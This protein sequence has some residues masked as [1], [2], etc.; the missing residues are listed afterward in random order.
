MEPLC[1]TSPDSPNTSAEPA[2]TIKQCGHVFGRDCLAEWMSEHNT[3]PVCR[4]EFF[5]AREERQLFALGVYRNFE[6]RVDG[7]Q[8]GVSVDVSVSV[9]NGGGNGT[10]ERRT[11]GD[12]GN[13]R[14]RYFVA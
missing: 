13:G 12:G 7:P 2:T 14:G 8:E 6:V 11:V 10:G 5:A 9:R 3:C 4:V 1:I